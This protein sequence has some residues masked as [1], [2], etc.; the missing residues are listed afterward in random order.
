[1]SVKVSEMLCNE[2]NIA[3]NEVQWI[4][5]FSDDNRCAQRHFKCSMRGFTSHNNCL[6][7]KITNKYTE[8]FGIFN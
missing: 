3:D 7:K 6:Q 2:L 4:R 5:H 1:M 8:K